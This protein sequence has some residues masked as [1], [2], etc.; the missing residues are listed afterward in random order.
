ML[1]R[2]KMLAIVK[3]L[4]WTLQ[5]EKFD[6]RRYLHQEHHHCPQSHQTAHFCCVLSQPGEMRLAEELPIAQ[7]PSLPVR[8]DKKFVKTAYSASRLRIQHLSLP[9]AITAS[10]IS[11]AWVLLATK[12]LISSKGQY[13]RLMLEKPNDLSRKGK[14]FSIV[15]TGLI[16]WVSSIVSSAWCGWNDILLHSSIL[17]DAWWGLQRE[18]S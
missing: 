13:S 8:S 12:L 4:Q 18:P 2:Y 3:I 11:P 6:S 15:V 17:P 14:R 16:T 10:I 1:I 9:Y 7:L 5:I